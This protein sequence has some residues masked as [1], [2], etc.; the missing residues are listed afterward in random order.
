MKRIFPVFLALGLILGIWSGKSLA[1]TETYQDDTLVQASVTGSSY[2]KDYWY[3]IIGGNEYNIS[4]IGVTW[5]GDDIIISIY[6]NTSGNRISG[7]YVADVALDLDQNDVWETGIVLKN[8]DRGSTYSAN[9]MYTFGNSNNDHWQISDNYTGGVYGTSYDHSN[10][11]NSTGTHDPYDPPVLLKTAAAPISDDPVT[12]NWEGI[13][14]GSPTAY[15]ITLTLTG[16]NADGDWNAFDLLWAT[17][18]C[19]NDTQYIQA[20]SPVPIPGSLLLLGTGILG[21]GLLGRRR[22][23]G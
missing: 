3:D 5:N 17:Q 11:P 22:K 12:V 15:L 18:T 19:A 14:S 7:D 6:T 9:S 1:Y 2:T 20:Y 8:D 4:Q 13:P 10:N 16:V 23:R 21:L